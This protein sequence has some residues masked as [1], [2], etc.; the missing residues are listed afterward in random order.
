VN[1][2]GAVDDVTRR[3]LEVNGDGL[4]AGERPVC[5]H[6]RHTHLTPLEVQMEGEATADE[7][8]TELI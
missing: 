4:D 7:M 1:K 5:S 8:K 6:H 3:E 2:V